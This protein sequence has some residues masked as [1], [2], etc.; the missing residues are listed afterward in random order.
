MH[1]NCKGGVQHAAGGY[2]KPAEAQI[3]AME[4]QRGHPQYLE[5]SPGPA[6]LDA[7]SPV[8]MELTNDTLQAGGN[9]AGTTGPIPFSLQHGDNSDSLPLLGGLTAVRGGVPVRPGAEG[10]MAP[11]EGTHNITDCVPPLSTLL[12]EDEEDGSNAGTGVEGPHAHEARSELHQ[13]AAEADATDMELTGTGVAHCLLQGNAGSSSKSCSR[14]ARVPGALSHAGA[15]PTGAGAGAGLSS[16]PPAGPE[17]SPSRYAT[18]SASK[19]RPQARKP[20]QGLPDNQQPSLRSSVLSPQ[21]AVC[22]PLRISTPVGALAPAVATAELGAAGE[23]P[24]PSP[25]R[26]V[27]RSMLSPSPGRAGAAAPGPSPARGRRSAAASS[28]SGGRAGHAI[29]MP[30]GGSKRPPSQA[31]S[32][33]SGSHADITEGIDTV[34]LEQQQNKW[35]LVPGDE[36]TLALALD[37]HGT[38]GPWGLVG[39]RADQ[40]VALDRVSGLG[41]EGHLLV[42]EQWWW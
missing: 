19:Q 12:E 20:T 11:A 31:S 34:L 38:R 23:G 17:P 22:S 14:L 42:D 30:H 24:T 36:D 4:S 7:L 25:L 6:P 21:R 10:N 8:S 39:D 27:T 15:I 16:P 2:S 41:G 32:A 40:R 33:R 1:G 18:R 28:P 5:N 35:G 13:E 26:R 3:H 9:A 37:R 29:N